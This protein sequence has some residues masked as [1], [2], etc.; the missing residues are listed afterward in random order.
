MKKDEKKPVGDNITRKDARRVLRRV[1]QKEAFREGQWEII[2]PILKGRDVIGVM[3]TG[4]GKSLCYQMMAALL[5]SVVVV[6]SPLISL[7]DDQVKNS[8][9]RAGC[10]HSGKPYEECLNVIRDA[11]TSGGGYLLYVSPERA[12]S[13]AFMRD[14]DGVDVCLLAFDEAHCI[15]QWGHDFRPEYSRV[16][17][18]RKWR[19]APVMA[20]TASATPL[21]IQEIGRTIG[22][23]RALVRVFGFYRPNLYFQVQECRNQQ[24]KY[25]WLETSINQFTSGRILVYTST[26]KSCE[27]IAKRLRR[28]IRGETIGVYHAGMSPDDRAR[29]QEAYASGDARVLV[30]TNAFGMGIDHPDI[31][32]V[33]HFAMP[34]SI[35]AL[36]QETGRAGRDG[37]KSLCLLLVSGNDKGLQAFFIGKSPPS[38]RAHQWHRL[39]A[40]CSY[41]S[42]GVGGCRHRKIL[43]YFNQ[44]TSFS[45]GHCDLCDPESR[46][47]NT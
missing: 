21:V 8:M 29:T 5:E 11:R 16:G 3:P 42:M 40:M 33:V 12:V 31:R 15:S 38:A 30:A 4:G 24:E 27:E 26:R 35:D 34:G 37:Q 6:V 22:T 45:C 19:D 28:V 7:M 32:F 13:E 18:L 43:E 39:N 14:M 25:R 47:L 23:R 36:Y 41:V 20:L 10:L 44:I 9:V 46:L 1:F 17:L 2:R